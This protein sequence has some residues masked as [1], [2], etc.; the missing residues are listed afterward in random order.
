MAVKAVN[1]TGV[2]GT[3]QARKE[4]VLSA[5]TQPAFP[6]Y[7]EPSHLPGLDQIGCIQTPQLLELS[8]ISPTV[9]LRTMQM[10]I[11]M[12]GIGNRTRLQAVGISSLIDL[13]GVGENFQVRHELLV[14]AIHID[15]FS[16]NLR[17]T[18]LCSHRI[19]RYSIHSSR[20]VSAIPPQRLDM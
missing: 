16:T 10:L 3:I 4:V 19:S 11:V 13:P 17:R 6:S 1:T 5:G 20:T 9:V 12:T 15:S 14:Q 7:G 2:S 8:G 18:I